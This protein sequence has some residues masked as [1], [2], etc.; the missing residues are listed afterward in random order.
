MLTTIENNVRSI[1]FD[2]NIS[3]SV[4]IALIALLS[5]IFVA[6]INN[7]M[8]RRT[9]QIELDHEIN[10]KKLENEKE[11]QINKYEVYYKHRAEIYENMLK[12]VGMFLA[13]DFDF[14][15]YSKALGSVSVAYGYADQELAVALDALKIQLLMF[16]ERAQGGKSYPELSQALDNVAKIISNIVSEDS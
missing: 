3:V 7:C 15:K 13:G 5:P 2:W 11:I 12:E 1:G 4:I 16:H 9:R 14:E 6:I 8:Q 10:M